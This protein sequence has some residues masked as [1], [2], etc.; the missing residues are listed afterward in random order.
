MPSFQEEY[1]EMN[2]FEPLNGEAPVLSI[3]TFELQPDT[4]YD[5]VVTVTDRRVHMAPHR[6]SRASGAEEWEVAAEE[7][8]SIKQL[9][10]GL[11]LVLRSTTTTHRFVGAPQNLESLMDTHLDCS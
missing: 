8:V 3:E 10:E 6:L 5:G 9:V 4:L 7:I 11:V 1:K 2:T